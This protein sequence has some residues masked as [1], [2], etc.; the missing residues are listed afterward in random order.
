MAITPNREQFIALAS[1]PDERPVVMI[2]LLKFKTGPGPG[3]ESS[4]AASYNQYSDKV[5]PMVEAQGGKLLWMGRVDQVLI[6]DSDADA[7]DAAAL[8]QYPSRKA[9]IE[10]VTSKDYNEAHQHRE[11]GLERTVLLACT[12]R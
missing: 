4:G 6:G 1:A 7:W 12:E 11:D 5:R 3:D 8:V 2:N 9:F 10:M